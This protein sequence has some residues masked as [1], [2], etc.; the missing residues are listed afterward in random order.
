MDPGS[1][2]KSDGRCY[3][4]EVAQVGWALLWGGMHITWRYRCLRPRFKL[5]AGLSAMGQAV[6]TSELDRQR[7]TSSLDRVDVCKSSRSNHPTPRVEGT[8]LRTSARGG[9]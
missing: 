9:M 4:V 6:R 1:G 8:R 2:G 3:V 5:R 7:C